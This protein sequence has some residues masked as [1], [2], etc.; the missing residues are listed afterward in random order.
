MSDRCYLRLMP[1]GTLGLCSISRSSTCQQTVMTCFEDAEDADAF[2]ERRPRNPLRT[3]GWSVSLHSSLR[4]MLLRF[5]RCTIEQRSPSQSVAVGSMH[6]TSTSIGRTD[7]RADLHFLFGQG[8][9]VSLRAASVF[10]ALW[11]SLVG[12][13]VSHARWL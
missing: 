12:S 2:R 7:G 9:A 10:F 1:N 8:S 4:S 13:R 5:I 11:V 3:E 6:Y